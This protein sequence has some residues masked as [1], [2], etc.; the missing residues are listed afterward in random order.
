[1]IKKLPNT[2]FILDSDLFQYSKYTL[3]QMSQTLSFTY[4]KDHQN[5]KILYD[6]LIFDAQLNVDLDKLITDYLKNLSINQPGVSLY[7]STK[8]FLYIDGIS[9]ISK[10]K[11]K[12]RTVFFFVQKTVI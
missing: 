8:Y 3:A 10:L 1:M 9:I 6:Q 4:I 11:T 5:K 2:T 7:P 12:I